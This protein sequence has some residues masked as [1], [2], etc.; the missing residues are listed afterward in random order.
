MP[1][2]QM[3]CSRRRP[4][5]QETEEVWVERFFLR[6]QGMGFPE[7]NLGMTATYDDRRNEGRDTRLSDPL[8]DQLEAIA[9]CFIVALIDRKVE[10]ESTIDLNVNISWTALL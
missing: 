2:Q 9:V 4:W 3:R 10:T 8:C 7:D 1:A 5:P 6:L